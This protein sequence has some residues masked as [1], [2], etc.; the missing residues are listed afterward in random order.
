MQCQAIAAVT[1]VNTI[2]AKEIANVAENDTFDVEPGVVDN[3]HKVLKN[4][5]SSF[6]AGT[7]KD[8]GVTQTKILCL[9]AAQYCGVVK[10][11]LDTWFVE[12]YASGVVF[13]SIA[14]ESVVCTVLA[15]CAVGVVERLYKCFKKAFVSHST[16]TVGGWTLLNVGVACLLKGIGTYSGGTTRGWPRLMAWAWQCVCF[17]MC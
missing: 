2:V 16:A 1:I 9:Q 14:W 17:V 10:V 12:N 13:C 4:V 5:A 15:A 3:S 6:T 7:D 11:T 8:S